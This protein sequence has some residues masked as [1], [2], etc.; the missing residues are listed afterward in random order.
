M[1]AK[2]QGNGAKQQVFSFSLSFA[3]VYAG[4]ALGMEIEARTAFP[5]A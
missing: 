1:Y 3:H 2:K 5:R 4:A